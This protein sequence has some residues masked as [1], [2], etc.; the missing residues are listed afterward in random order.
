M[1]K[2][3]EDALVTKKQIIEES[4]KLFLQKGFLVTTLDEI[5]QQVN[6]T[7]GAIYHHFKDKLDIVNEL[8]ETEHL[9][10]KGLL[11][12]I[13]NENIAPL[14]KIEKVIEGVVNN[15]FDNK[16]FQDFIEL[17]WFKIEYSQL[18]RLRSS[19]AELTGFFIENFNRVVIEAQRNGVIKKDVNASHVTITI[20]NM[21]NGM[22]R[23]FFILPEQ[24]NTKKET[25][26]FFTSY[27]NLIKI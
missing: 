14:D 22:Y 11:Q 23:L 7:R 15:F 10:L 17:T 4:V 2:T 25:M 26:S 19:K 21:I 1:R 20:I 3:K 6:V 18:T 5:A 13:F 8:I 12:K 24:F 27:L 9:N 16:S